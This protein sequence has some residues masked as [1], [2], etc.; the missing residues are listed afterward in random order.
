MFPAIPTTFGIILGVALAS[1][2]INYDTA[3]IA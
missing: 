3:I 1:F 2:V